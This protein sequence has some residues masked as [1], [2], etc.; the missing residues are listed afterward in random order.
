MQLRW[1][2]TPVGVDATVDITQ[3]EIGGFL[4]VTAG[5]LTLTR[6]DGSVIFTAL[7]V[8]AGSW[9]FLPF[10]VGHQGGTLV[11]AGGASG[12]LAA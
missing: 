3:N 9:T 1:H 8:T 10:Y 7:P 2:P 11:A 6:A 12:V 5:T 4:A